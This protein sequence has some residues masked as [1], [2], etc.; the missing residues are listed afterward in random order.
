M[1]SQ[2]FRKVQRKVSLTGEDIAV[3]KGERQLLR[4]SSNPARCVPQKSRK[5]WEDNADA[6]ADCCMGDPTAPKES[7]HG[8]FCSLSPAWRRKLLVGVW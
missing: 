5:Q 3:K 8:G 6:K 2:P 7:H 4:E 1:T